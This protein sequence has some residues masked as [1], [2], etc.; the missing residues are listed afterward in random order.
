MTDEQKIYKLIRTKEFKELQSIGVELNL[1]RNRFDILSVLED[2]IDENAWSRIFAYILDSTKEHGIKQVAFRKWLSVCQQTHP[3]LTA[4]IK[5]LPPKNKCRV[6]CETEWTDKGRRLDILIRILNESNKTVAV[7]GVENKVDSGELE[8][9]VSDY[10]KSLQDNFMC[11]SRI[12]FFLSPDGRQSETAEKNES[13]PCIPISYNTIEKVCVT[14][15]PEIGEEQKVFVSALKNHL[16]KLTN[17][18]TMDKKIQQLVIKLYQNPNYSQGIDLLTQFVPTT[19]AMFESLTNKMKTQNEKLPFNFSDVKIEFYPKNK[20]NPQEYKVTPIEFE[21]LVGNRYQPAYIFRCEK[22]N[23]SR[24]DIFTLRFA[25]YDNNNDNKNLKN[26]KAEKI[27]NILCSPELINDGK[28]WSSWV[29]IAVFDSH[30]LVDLDNKD[31]L[32]L[33]KKLTE[34]INQSYSLIK[35]NLVKLKMARI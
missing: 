3:Q 2:L 4:F 22:N 27:K 24:K 16:Q 35:D 33:S 9:Q 34:G 20:N 6:I 13:C 28:I 10:Q 5:K 15:I 11:K 21:K 7:I 30:S 8:N 17:S 1:E 19:R 26:G 12:I 29:N 18:N 32:L 25:V 23:P 31:V 14:I